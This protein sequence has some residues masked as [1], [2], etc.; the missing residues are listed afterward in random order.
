MVQL[1]SKPLEDI[2][3]LESRKFLENVFGDANGNILTTVLD[4]SKGSKDKGSKDNVIKHYTKDNVASI[5][6]YE[7]ASYNKKGC[8]IYYAT[9]TRSGNSNSKEDVLKVC[10]IF[11]DIDAKYFKGGKVEAYKF[12]QETINKY[13]LVP[14]YLIDSGNGYHL[15][16]VLSAPIQ[17]NNPDDIKKVE[18]IS[19]GISK[20]FHADHLWYVSALS[21]IPGFYNN[22]DKEAPKLIEVVSY[23]PS[24]KYDLSDLEKYSEEVSYKDAS[25]TVKLDSVPPEI[26]EKF[27][28]L[29]DQDP[30]LK[31]RW[32]GDASGL[33]DQSGSGIDLSIANILTRNGFTP[34]ETAS[35]IQHA[36]YPK[37]SP[38]SDSYIIRTVSKAY[39]GVATEATAFHNND[40]KKAE[41]P[42]EFPLGLLPNDVQEIVTEIAD[43]IPCP[44]DYV[45]NGLLSYCASAIGGSRILHIKGTWYEESKLWC[46]TIAPSGEGKSPA[47]L[48]F[49]TILDDKQEL[50]DLGYEDTEKRYKTH[51]KIYDS[52]IKKYKIEQVSDIH[53]IPIEPTEPPK[54]TLNVT[55]VTTEALKQILKDN[56]R[57][58]IC[59]YD[60]FDSYLKS[61][62]QYKGH[63]DD[64][65]FWNKLWNPRTSI[66]IGRVHSKKPYSVRNSI[67]SIHGSITPICLSDLTYKGGEDGLISRFLYVYPDYKAYEETDK[68]VSVEATS[69]LEFIFERLW[70]LEPEEVSPFKPLSVG[71]NSEAQRLWSNYAKQHRKELNGMSE[72]NPFRAPHSKLKTY[73]ARLSLVIQ[74]LRYACEEVED[75][76]FVDE[77]S[78][79]VAVELERYYR[80]HALKVWKKLS[81]IQEDN[82]YI[83][84][85]KKIKANGGEYSVRDAVTNKLCGVST[86]DDAR[87]LFKQLED[88]G[89]GK[90]E[91]VGR[92]G[93]F[94]LYLEH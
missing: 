23:N 81:I 92:S 58:I 11:V 56:P 15:H 44:I 28:I 83:K 87:D 69:K 54:T 62:N 76:Y 14:T 47:V 77:Y 50:L 43:S 48:Q 86:A 90:L 21:R 30:P 35:V 59:C 61:M 63:G 70:Q 49:N 73:T 79:S 37:N 71:Y 17:I 91:Q 94:T 60:E 19:M 88:A 36:P 64:R 52:E 24:Q 1:G 74:G 89:H 4:K 20:L 9:N 67:V 39:E 3:I 78:M 5:K 41:K 80:S 10:E 31:A 68:G 29:L 25:C 75:F 2:N 66:V 51:K 72:N 46:V 26:P 18:K 27:S 38:R 7:L 8:D 12:L 16:F 82:F 42:L 65:Q 6:F 13:Q 57:G 93:V 34:E 33:Q 32:N 40:F 55:D 84:A 85:V 45:T 22:K 53:N